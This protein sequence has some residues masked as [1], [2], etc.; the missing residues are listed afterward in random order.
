MTSGF[1]GTLESECSY[2]EVTQLAGNATLLSR[3]VGIQLSVCFCF[4][5]FSLKAN[6]TLKT[7]ESQHLLLME[8]SRKGLVKR[9][10][11]NYN[12]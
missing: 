4:I 3:Y 12:D 8:E 9:E 1:S 5:F 11:K 10:G 6:D 2:R 7:T